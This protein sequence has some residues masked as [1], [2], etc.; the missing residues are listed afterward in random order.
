M[1]D[2]IIY[3]LYYILAQKELCQAHYF[4]APNCKQQYGLQAFITKHIKVSVT[5]NFG[6]M[7]CIK[8]NFKLN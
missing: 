3:I 5:E 1:Y 4:R 6:I 8:D 7:G 2:C